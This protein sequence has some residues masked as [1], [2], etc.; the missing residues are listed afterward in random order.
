MERP[1]YQLGDRV[2]M[3]KTHPCGSDIFTIVRTGADIKIKC[4][5]CGRIIML[6]RPTFEK[7]LKAVLPS[8][9]EQV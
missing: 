4:Q 2:R 5:G 8:E 7:R 1:I 3:R 9:G 6:D